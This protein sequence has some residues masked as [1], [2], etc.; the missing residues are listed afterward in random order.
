MLVR[1]IGNALPPR[2]DPTRAL[3]NLRFFLEH[4]QLDSDEL[5][6]HW[7][8]NRLA[9]AQVARQFRELLAE[10]DA[11][12]TELPLQLEQYARAPFNVIVEDHG[13]DRVHME[14]PDDDQWTRN[15]DVNAIYASKNRYALGINAARNMML[16]IARESGARW[17][18]PWDQT[19]FLTKDAWGQIKHDLDNAAPDQKYFMAFMDRLTQENEVVLSPEFKADPWEEPQI[20][21][22]NDSV[23]RFDEQLRYG[24]RDKAALLVRLQVNGVWNGWGWSSWEQQR[25]YANLSKDVS[26]PDAVPSTGYVIRLYS[27]LESAV[28]ANTASAGFWREIRRAKGVVKV[29]DK[30]EERVM[31]E[32]LDYRPDKVLVYDEA[33]LHRYKEQF[34]T[35]EGKQ[36]ISNL[37]ADADRAL[38]VSK[39]WKVTSNEA[40]DPEHDP[41]IF[42]NY[43]DRDDGVSD[44]GELIQDMA[45]NTTALALAWSL[46]GDKQYVIQASTFLEAWCH[47][48]S[49]LMRAT[50]EYADMSYQKLLTNT[51]G[52]TKGSVMGIR[53]TAVIPMLLDAIRL[54]NTTS[55]NSSEGVLPHDLSDKI[56]R[57]TRDLFGSLQSES[58]R[59]TFRW[60]P[61]LFAMLYDIQ[62][63]ALGAFLNDSKLLR[64]TLGTIHGR[65]MT[66]MSPEEKL[67]VPTGVA[68]KPYTLLMLSTWGFAAD[69]AQR[70]G[71]SRHLFQFDLTRDRREE[72]V[73]EEGGLLC[74]FIGHSVPCCQAEATSRAS[75]HQC[76]RALQHVDEAQLFV[77][78]RIVR[79]AVEQCPILR[80]RPSC[81]SLARI[82]PNFK[83][84]S[85]H[86]MSRY[87]LPPYPFL[88]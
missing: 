75:A 68:T 60:S 48:P 61:G 41:Q 36:T 37:L 84:L 9:D 18:L 85:A 16:D 39:P 2:H 46:T 27:G 76:V 1:A 67:L 30:L 87:L 86:E 45:Y 49:S 3:R 21:F 58:A 5:A 11:P 51:A 53:H 74:R 57:W 15:Q 40:L 38:E 4:E 77:Y 59:Y 12:Y 50:L 82:E 22:R 54:L 26:G 81:A 83:T 66:M 79:Q 34:N 17:L 73:N 44:D 8:L 55:I 28:E 42:A 78:S 70:Y 23:E 13:E 7:V 32:L 88:R 72:R 19:C 25:T 6:T 63:A 33:L 35:E 20:I 71:L 69:L 31:V 24:Q 80:K 64:Y 56:V 62:V 14:L 52:N 29:L 10:F 43:Y 47:D 65:L